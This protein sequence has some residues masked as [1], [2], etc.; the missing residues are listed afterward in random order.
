MESGL[1][2]QG[3]CKQERMHYHLRHNRKDELIQKNLD[4]KF[5]FCEIYKPKVETNKLMQNTI[6]IILI[7]KFQQKTQ[8]ELEALYYI[9][10]QDLKV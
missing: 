4:D 2:H 5:N 1:L 3:F 6:L 9:F 7:R 10:F 8:K